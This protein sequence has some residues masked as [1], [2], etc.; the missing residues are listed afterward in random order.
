MMDSTEKLAKLAEL[1]AS[2]ALTEEEF[3]EQKRKV[4]QGDEPAAAPKKERSG[5]FSLRSPKGWILSF[6]GFGVY[7][8][9]KAG[10][11]GLGEVTLPSCDDKQVASMLVEQT[12]N[13]IRSNPMARLMAGNTRIVSIASAKELH[14]DAGLR[15]CEGVV[16]RNDGEGVVGFTIEWQNKEDGLFWV[17][18][19]GIDQLRAKYTKAVPAAAEMPAAA[20]APVVAQAVEQKPVGD[21]LSAD[22][23]ECNAE[24]A[25]VPESEACA[26]TEIGLQKKRLEDVVAQKSISPD[27]HAQWVSGMIKH[28]NKIRDDS[29]S[30]VATLYWQ[31]CVAK[32]TA[33]RVGAL[34]AMK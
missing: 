31:E 9:F 28:C 3:A 26:I 14:S 12:N 13:Q 17:T 24:A 32:E 33:K 34:A 5:W 7:L 25:R 1:K 18:Q 6:L 10:A 15:A 21:S 30:D 29:E 16:K 4:L 8:A 27:E 2:G 23:K 20:P 11:M 22:W 19:V